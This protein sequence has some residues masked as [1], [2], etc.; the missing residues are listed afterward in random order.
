MVFNFFR[1]DTFSITVTVSGE[2]KQH[3]HTHVHTYARHCRVEAWP[4]QN[5]SKL[6]TDTTDQHELINDWKMYS[7]SSVYQT[8]VRYISKSVYHERHAKK[9]CWNTGLIQSS[10]MHA[11]AF[12]NTLVVWIIVHGFRYRICM[13]AHPRCCHRL[14]CVECKAISNSRT[15]SSWVFQQFGTIC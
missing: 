10:H 14:L 13:C 3:T 5:V 15:F 9:V 4:W 7:T 1:S 6:N 2:K 11:E 12:H 8:K